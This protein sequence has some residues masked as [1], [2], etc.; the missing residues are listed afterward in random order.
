MNRLAAQ[1]GFWAA[2]LS[3][4]TFVGYTV[5]YFAILASGPLFL[6][7]GL[8]DYVRLVQGHS[9]FFADL[10]R[11]LMLCFAA[12]FVVLLNAI[13][14]Y[15][16]QEHKILARTAL[17][18]GLGFAALVGVNYFVQLSTV[19]LAIAKGEWQGLEQIVQANPISAVAAVN[20]LGWTVFLGL[21]S[22]FAAPVFAGGRLQMG[23]RWA[24]LANAVCCLLGGVGYVLNSFVVVLLT[25]TFGMG[26]AVTVAVVGLCLLFRRVQAQ[27]A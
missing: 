22:L 18:F 11:L 15:A 3:A 4:A 25:I 23:I 6:W 24:L 19:R 5:C 14:E 13:Y 10:A 17:C 26:A 7:S 20:M 8:Q 27:P 9:Q 1:L 21:A 2:L 12:L 16:C